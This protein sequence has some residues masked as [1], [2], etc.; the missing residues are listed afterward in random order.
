[1]SALNEFETEMSENQTKPSTGE[2]EKKLKPLRVWPAVLLIIGMIVLKCLPT[3][4]KDSP[5]ELYML[6]AFGPML[7]GGLIILWWL[8]ASRASISERF[9]GVF[10]LVAITA[11]S[12]AVVHPSMRGPGTMTITIPMGAFA[13]AIGAILL[14]RRLHTS[15]TV[16]ALLIAA[17]SISFSVL[18]RY[19][20]VWG[21]FNPS[22]NWRW[23]PTAED[24][25]L[26]D[27]G[28][29]SKTQ[30]EIPVSEVRAALENPQWAG[31]RGN[32]RDGIVSG[33]DFE[34]DWADKPPKELWRISV[35]PGWSSF[36][37]AG[38]LLFTQEQRGT[39]ECV[40][41]YESSSGLEIWVHE[42]ESRFFDPLGGPGPRATPT[43]AGG[44][45]YA[46]GAEGL[47]IKIDPVVGKLIWQVDLREVANVEPPDW[48]FCASPLVVGDK[49]ITYAAGENDKGVVAFETTNGEPAWSVPAGQQSYSS[50]H[51]CS[52]NGTEY[53]VFLTDKGIHFIDPKSGKSASDYLWEQFGY[54]SLQPYM[55]N[56]DSM[57]LPTGAGAGTRRI[58]FDGDLNGEEVWTSM[59]LK[60]DFND[61]VVHNGHIFGFDDT[62]FTCIDIETG[63]RKWK[64]GRYGKGQVLLLLDSNAMLV[65]SEKGELV[66]L[67]TDAE[68]N[69]ELSKLKVFD[70]K[71]WNH[72]I[73]V[74]DRL[75]L[76]NDREAVCLVLP[77]KA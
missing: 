71:T 38:N 18:L 12:L 65:I 16:I 46:M 44:F 73:I 74:G 66:L 9:W 19:D 32:Q 76:R 49:V 26:T 75:Y 13:F 53:V 58:K 17:I 34:T 27:V 10:C 2:V 47:L 67:K 7:L 51:L 14:A 33:T 1:M 24:V 37:M 48:G 68:Q 56:E 23:I 20:G 62:I 77:T 57:L 69:V 40:V 42:I 22:L 54:R 28:T 61:F 59:A 50:P 43:L 60:P 4:W 63:E 36:A 39:N 70:S 45:L 8:L 30:L 6:A 15:R 64:R 29:R 72:P 11:I 3:L 35:G 52:V 5:A 25:F 41:C 21:D 55:I 31:F